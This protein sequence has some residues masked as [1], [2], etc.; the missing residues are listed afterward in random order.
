MW[1]IATLCV[2]ILSVAET[3]MQ[4]GSACAASAV[5]LLVCLYGL[6]IIHPLI[7][8]HLPGLLDNTMVM[9]ASVPPCQ[10]YG[11]M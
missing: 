9:R 11:P 1:S 10:R 3:N 6:T 2:W 8:T 5:L 7:N 4:W